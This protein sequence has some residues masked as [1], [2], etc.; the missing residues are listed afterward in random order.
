[1]IITPAL[2]RFIA[3]GFRHVPYRDATDLGLV[4]LENASQRLFVDPITGY[5]RVGSNSPGRKGH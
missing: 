1:M 3:N 4:C 5:C 2:R